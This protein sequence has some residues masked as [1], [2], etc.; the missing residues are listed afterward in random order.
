VPKVFLDTNILVYTLDKADV[1]KREQARQI[2]KRVIQ[3]H[4]PVISTQVIKEFYVVAATKLKADPFAVKNI[5]RGFRN[6]EIV[7]NDLDLVEQAIDI[8][9][10]SQLSFW[11]ALIVAAAEKAKCE[12]ILSEDMGAGQ[13]FRGVRLVNPFLEQF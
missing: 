11:D 6:M 9:L 13:S 4:H 12:L 3:Q 1:A 2:V 7:N 8:S 5:I 10:A